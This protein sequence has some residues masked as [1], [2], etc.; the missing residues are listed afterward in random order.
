L[1]IQA[2]GLN[3]LE[4]DRGAHE[5]IVD[6]DEGVGDGS[7]ELQRLRRVA[8]E[9][10]EPAAAN[11]EIDYKLAR[12]REHIALQNSATKTERRK[13]LA[14]IKALRDEIAS[15]RAK[16]RFPLLPGPLRRRIAK[17]RER[18]RIRSEMR[19][20]R[21]SGLFD[22]AWYTARYRDVGRSG[23]DPLYHYV[24]YGGFEGRD[25]NP[26][27]NSD[28]YSRTYLKVVGARVN[29]LLDYVRIGSKAGRDPGPFFRATP[30]VGKYQGVERSGLDPLLYFQ[31]LGRG[32]GR[33]PFP[34][35][36]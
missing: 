1:H 4:L 21:R 31:R 22:A 33:G 24:R 18:L 29:P 7:D 27:F 26:H 3:D 6:R 8:D 11:A 34:L 14:E 5:M 2:D 10:K 23:I 15:L 19:E 13:Y 32:Q 12:V 35:R 9:Q 25:P 36:H 17:W 30:H 28:W 20:L 16:P